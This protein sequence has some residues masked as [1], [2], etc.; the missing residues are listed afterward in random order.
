MKH[1][2]IIGRIDE[3]GR[4]V[5]PKAIREELGIEEFD[6]LEFLLLTEKL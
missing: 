2:G 5:V 1:T 4:V 3:I 6:P